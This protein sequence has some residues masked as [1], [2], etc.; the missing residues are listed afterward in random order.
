MIKDYYIGV[1]EDRRDPKKLGRFRVRILGL[2]PIETN[3]LATNDLPWATVITPSGGNSGLGMTPPF[4]VEGTWVYIT[5][6]DEGKQEPLIHGS[7]SGIP[8][9]AGEIRPLEGFRDPYGVYPVEAG[10]SDVNELARGETDA[11]NP[12]AR[13]NKRRTS[14]ATSDFDGFEIPTVGDNLTVS[15][16]AGGSFD[17]PAI[18]NGT[19]APS[20]P[21]NHVFATEAGHVL[22]FDDTTGSRRVH[23][24]HSSG[25]YLEYSNDG[26]LV[27]HSISEKYNV[28]NSNSFSFT[29]GNEVQ[30]IDGSLKVKVNKSDTAGNHYDIEVGS[31]ANINIMVRGGDLNMNVKGNVNQFIDGDLNASM[32]NLR[33]DA[34]NKITMTA[35]GQI[36]IDGGS[37]DIDGTPIDLN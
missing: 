36:K 37:V 32:D 35:G 10:V 29:G 15:G 3:L 16:S 1:I 34:S 17:M 20:Y 7:L 12:T 13:E 31:G 24:S 19:Y 4:F 27:S 30:S 33:L 8:E 28:V 22:E 5:F 26:T 21:F 23:L 25:S 6:R 9:A 18:L 2:H 14:V 11:A